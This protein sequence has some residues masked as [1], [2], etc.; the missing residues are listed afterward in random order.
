MPPKTRPMLFDTFAVTAGYPRASSIGK[1]MS[2]PE[3][4]TA[5]IMPAATPAAS[6]ASACHAVTGRPYPPLRRGSPA[7]LFLRDQ[8]VAGAQPVQAAQRLRHARVALEP[9]ANPGRKAQ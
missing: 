8:S 7:C 6:T 4:T 5:L 1:V 2:V 3:P 9:R